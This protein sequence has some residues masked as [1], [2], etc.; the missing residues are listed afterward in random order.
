MQ[1]N[2]FNNVNSV[3]EITQAMQQLQMQYQQLSLKLQTALPNA[4][5]KP[6][7]QPSPVFSSI[8]KQASPEKNP[9]DIYVYP[10]KCGYNGG[11]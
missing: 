11:E 4:I 10:A 8:P 1:V 7:T 6:V 2:N 9:F 3:Q 5:S